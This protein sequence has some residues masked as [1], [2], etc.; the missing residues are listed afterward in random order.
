MKSASAVNRLNI[1]GLTLPVGRSMYR[2]VLATDLENMHTDYITLL[3]S[4]FS[5]C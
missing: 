2:L 3:S 5:T 4:C 1:A